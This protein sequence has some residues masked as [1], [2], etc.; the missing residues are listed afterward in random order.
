MG[1]AASA[2]ALDAG[3]DSAADLA[4]EHRVLTQALSDP[5]APRHSSDVQT[6]SQDRVLAST[7]D[8]TSERG[9]VAVRE[10]AVEACRECQGGRECCRTL[11]P[12]YAIRPVAVF[13]RHEVRFADGREVV[14]RNGQLVLPRQ[15]IDALQSAAN[16]LLPA[17]HHEP[18][19]VVGDQA[20]SP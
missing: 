6:R 2:F 3:A 19:G 10:V 15:P 12:A 4:G 16:R 9:T 14:E 7:E 17:A 11:M 20:V 13:E 1:V 8:L 18:L 5:A